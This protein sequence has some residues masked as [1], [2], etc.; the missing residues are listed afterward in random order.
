MEVGHAYIACFHDNYP[1]LPTAKAVAKL[2]KVGRTYAS[3]VIEELLR[4]G[5][6]IDPEIIKEQR[7]ELRLPK[8]HLTV[9]EELFLLSLWTENPTRPNDSY[10]RG[11]RDY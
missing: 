3:L 7:I 11:L 2:A 9:K 10:A 8:F 1:H 6:I 4:T 5:T